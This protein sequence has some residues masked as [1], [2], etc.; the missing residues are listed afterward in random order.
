MQAENSLIAT[1]TTS[2]PA[3]PL[4]CPRSSTALSLAAASGWRWSDVMP[5]SRQPAKD[6]ERQRL[7]RL[8]H[9]AKRDLR[10]VDADYRA[11]LSTASFGEKSSAGDMTVPELERAIAHMKRCGFKVR[12]KGGQP[13]R[14]ETSRPMATDPES[15]KIRALWL[16]LHELGAIKNP[17]EAALAAYVRRIGKVDD[18]HWLGGQAAE[19]V[20][21]SLKKWAM[22]FLPAA[23]RKLAEQA[24]ELPLARGDVE[25]LN[26]ALSL[27]FR[28]GTFDP[29]LS[30]WELLKQTLARAE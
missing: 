20:I 19:R 21:E 2:M 29:M 4:V 12:T 25:R 17:S 9:V 14:R 15:Q 18:L 26:D 10:M 1:S 7:I 27:A 28:R 11:V 24:G 23:V 8:V 22:R 6:S 16:M 5:A 30:A 3:M 13:A